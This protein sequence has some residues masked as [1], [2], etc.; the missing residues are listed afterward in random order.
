MI[1][2]FNRIYECENCHSLL[3]VNE[4]DERIKNG[5]YGAPEMIDCSMC[6]AEMFLLAQKKEQE[7]TDENRKN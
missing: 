2:R 1:Y 5:H 4:S 3:I 7:N 6:G